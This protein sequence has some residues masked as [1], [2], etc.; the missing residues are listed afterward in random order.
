MKLNLGCG[1]NHIDG[2]LN[3]DKDGDPEV[4]VDLEVFPWPWKD[5][6]VD[7]IVMYHSL[8]HMGADAKTFAGIMKELYRGCSH[9]AVIHI[10]VP[11]PRHDHFLDDPTHVRVITPQLMC[12]FSKKLCLQAKAEGAPNSPL[13]LYHDI[14]FF[15][16]AATYTLDPVY[17]AK[18]K[19]GVINEQELAA[20][21]REHNT[22]I[23]EWRM[24]LRVIK[25]AAK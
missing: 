6:S 10:A 17:D 8:E 21:M 9:W 19:Q 3:V 5:G 22:V 14:D 7:E 2:F 1:Q 23:A 25:E 20:A 18:L 16:E 11:H 12:C 13:A 24:D 4:K 15:L